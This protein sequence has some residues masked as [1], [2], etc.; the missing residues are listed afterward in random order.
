MSIQP[1]I[2]ETPK[3]TN[4]IRGITRYSAYTGKIL[5]VTSHPPD[6][7]WGEQGTGVIQGGGCRISAKGNQTIT[8]KGS[9]RDQ[10]T[11]IND[12]ARKAVFAKI[13]HVPEE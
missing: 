6:S 4:I 8:R 7:I 1:Y 5:S 11:H 10:R 2:Q 9:N 12:E 13:P 3:A